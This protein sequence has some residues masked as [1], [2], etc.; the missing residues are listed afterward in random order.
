MNT[1]IQFED[2]NIVEAEPVQENNY[3]AVDPKVE[4][5]NKRTKVGLS[6]PAIVFA[7]VAAFFCL[8]S[9]LVW[10]GAKEAL[11][12]GDAGE[13]I[14]GGFILIIVYI[15]AAIITGIAT[16]PTLILSII[17]LAKRKLKSIALPI[18]LLVLCVGMIVSLIIG[19]VLL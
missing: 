13:A 16:I 5:R 19:I 3:T 4:K 15:G 1:N 14:F 8:V 12:S 7:V 2:N 10:S 18:I 11:T 6:I 17:L 9:W